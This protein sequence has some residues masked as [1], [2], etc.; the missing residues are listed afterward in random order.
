MNICF[1]SNIID[2]SSD[3]W[4]LDNGATIHACN[5]MQAVI[6]RRSPT[7]LK[8]YMYMGNGTRVQIDVLGVVRLRLGT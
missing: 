2:M 8:Q 1:E 5:Y 7:S 6:S 3:T 4:W